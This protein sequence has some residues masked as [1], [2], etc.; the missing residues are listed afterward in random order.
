MT[1][2]WGWS[3]LFLNESIQK[4]K[5]SADEVLNSYN[6][7]VKSD[8]IYAASVPTEMYVKNYKNNYNKVV[9]RQND[10]TLFKTT[11]LNIKT[12]LFFV[13]LLKQLF[14]HLNKS[15]ILKILLLLPIKLT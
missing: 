7:M 15:P 1:Q 10:H 6:F 14:Q 11:V 13:I 8:V 12:T 3:T 5:I 4:F 2:T 9:Y